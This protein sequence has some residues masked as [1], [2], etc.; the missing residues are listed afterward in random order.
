M[1]YSLKVSNIETFDEQ[2]NAM[3]FKISQALKSLE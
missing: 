2:I 1:L 3:Q